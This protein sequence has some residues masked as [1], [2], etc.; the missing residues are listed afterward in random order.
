MLGQY[1]VR[2]AA[3]MQRELLK[4]CM[5]DKTCSPICV[6]GMLTW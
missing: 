6:S 3:E 4:V 1:G 2:K 5:Q